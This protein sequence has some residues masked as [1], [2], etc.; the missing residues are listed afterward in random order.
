MILQTASPPRVRRILARSY[1]TLSSSII[2]KSAS[3]ERI[4]LTVV[5]D[6]DNGDSVRELVIVVVLTFAQ[7]SSIF[8]SGGSFSGLSSCK[9]T[10]V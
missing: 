2:C 5:V 9:S 1:S 7:T 4:A 6:D 3:R 8:V 10:V